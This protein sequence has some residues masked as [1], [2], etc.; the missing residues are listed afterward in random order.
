M[1]ASGVTSDWELEI[2]P[3]LTQSYSEE[4]AWRPLC[5]TTLFWRV[6]CL[7]SAFYSSSRLTLHI[8]W[9]L[10][11]HFFLRQTLQI[12]PKLWNLT[13]KQNFWYL[14]FLNLL[15]ND[16]RLALNRILCP[17][18]RKWGALLQKPGMSHCAFIC[19]LLLLFLHAHSS[20]LISLFRG[21]Q[22][23]SAK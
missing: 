21:R 6:G 8:G 13:S 22:G 14:K 11:W 7:P 10:R 1:P 17:R 16:P 20:L 15:I 9:P 19:L 18:G 3:F 5:I 23:S 2:H 4:A 12:Q